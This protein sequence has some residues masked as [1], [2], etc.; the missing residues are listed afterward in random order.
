[1]N[2]PTP[3]QYVLYAFGRALPADLRDWVRNDLV[4]D[5]AVARHLFRA[6]VPF[7]PLFVAGLL[8]PGP[9]ALRAASV[10]LAVILGL[11]YAF[12][13]MDMNR[14]RRLVQHGWPADLENPRKA[15]H[16]ADTRISYERLYR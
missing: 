15:S 11:I 6:M 10:L 2:R 4:G 12:A 9:L 13:F 8:V 3:L 5:H 14:G 7:L 16:R 1:M